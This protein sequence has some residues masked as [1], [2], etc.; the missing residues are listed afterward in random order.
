MP[1]KEEMDDVFHY[2]IHSAI[3]D[4][5]LVC[6][7][8]D[9]SAFTGNILQWVRERIKSATLVVADLSEANPNVY[10]EVG[11]AWGCG[12]PTI[13]LARDAAELRFDVQGHRCLLYKRI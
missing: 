5:G 1:F 3:R 4:A 8:A 10:L 13:L 11:Y 12:V 7:R 6:E 9:L 2:S